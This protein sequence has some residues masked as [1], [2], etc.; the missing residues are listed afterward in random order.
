MIH[1]AKTL[2]ILSNEF[3]LMKETEGFNLISETEYK[4]EQCFKRLHTWIFDVITFGIL[5]H[6]TNSFLLC[7]L[8]KHHSQ[9]WGKLELLCSAANVRNQS[10]T[11][12]SAVSVHVFISQ[13]A[14]IIITL[15]TSHKSTGTLMHKP[16]LPHETS[17]WSAY[18]HAV[19]RSRSSTHRRALL[20]TGWLDYAIEKHFHEPFRIMR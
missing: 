11:T 9:F 19:D 4:N 8:Y 15:E 14:P 3:V 5:M 10:I 18:S 17:V 13:V 2:L 1:R 16:V 6:C 12:M 7:I 20:E